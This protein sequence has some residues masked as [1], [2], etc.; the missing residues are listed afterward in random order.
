MNLFVRNRLNRNILFTI[1]FVSVN[2]ACALV[3]TRWSLDALG[4]EGFGNWIILSQLILIGMAFEQIIGVPVIQIISKFDDLETKRFIHTSFISVIFAVG[5]ILFLIF[6]GFNKQINSLL[7]EGNDH[8]WVIML[9]PFIIIGQ[10]YAAVLLSIICGEGSNHIVQ[11]IKIV[12]R[13]FH[14]ALAGILLTEL[15]IL[16]LALALAIFY[17]HIIIMGLAIIDRQILEKN[18]A[19]HLE[20][21]NSIISMSK[22]L[23]AS[24]VIGFFTEPFL[25]IYISHNVGFAAVANFEVAQRANVAFISI[26]VFSL[27]NLTP[28]VQRLSGGK[29]IYNNAVRN[30]RLKSYFIAGI[31]LSLGSLCLIYLSERLFFFWLG[32]YDPEVIHL[33]RLIVC[34]YAIHTLSMVDI[35]IL[36]GYGV[37]RVQTYNSLIILAVFCGLLVVV[38]MAEIDL[39]LMML[40]SFYL[41]AILSS[42]VFTLFFANLTYRHFGSYKP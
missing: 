20:V 17:C 7:F 34:T 1:I 8:F 6:I 28:F 36:N 37:T 24:R 15:Q 40:V 23:F 4:S 10:M 14:L 16:G 30:L 22:D 41:S 19:D 3:L 11:K 38:Y 2:M 31:L 35:H 39:T 12:A 18:M 42:A 9:I 5:L 32:D 21:R 29:N 33:F 13:L 26:P 27:A 25:K